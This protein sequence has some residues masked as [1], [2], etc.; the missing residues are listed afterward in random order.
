M[1]ALLFDLDGTMLVSDPIHEEVFRVLWAERGLPTPDG[2][3]A[4]GILGRHNLDVFA[5]FL[6]DEPDPQALSETK[7]AAFRER[8]PRPYPAMPGLEA[9]LAEAKRH[10]WGVAVVTNAPRINAEA[11]L[12]A[13][14]VRE[15]VDLLVIGDECA[16]A[17]P[18]PEPYLTAMREL[19]E[20]PAT[21]LA[22]E[23]SPSGIR[24][25]KA[26]GLHT[27]ALRST[28]DDAALRAAGADATLT[29]FTD[30]ALPAHL[31]RLTGD[32]P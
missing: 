8:L 31:A 32:T 18:D 27:L 16:R 24:A 22:F 5:E 6:P 25:A 3:Y 1:S 11:M 14:G 10:G 2:F 7:E 4:N 23:D 29:D 9:L 13:I 12:S 19:G 21:S 28:L 30:P 20:T 26:A 15:A 17:K